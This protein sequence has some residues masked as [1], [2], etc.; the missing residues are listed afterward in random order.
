MFVEGVSSFLLFLSSSLPPLSLL[1]GGLLHPSIHPASEKVS[2]TIHFRAFVKMWEAA[3]ANYGKESVTCSIQ[4]YLRCE[5]EES[6][7]RGRERTSQTRKSEHLLHIL[8]PLSE[9]LSHSLNME[10]FSSFVFFC[11]RYYSVFCFN[12]HFVVTAMTK[13]YKTD[14]HPESLFRSKFQAITGYPSIVMVI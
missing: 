8:L 9:S 13:C 7:K 10:Q 12:K 4:Y 2:C 11:S 6:W 14:Q 1:D 5:G 3:T